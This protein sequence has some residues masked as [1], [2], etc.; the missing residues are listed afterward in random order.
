MNF[1][2]CMDRIRELNPDAVILVQTLYTSWTFDY[3]KKPY[4]QAAKRIND[5]II[6]YC[7]ENSYNIYIVETGEAFD[8]H[9]EYISSDTIHPSAEGNVVLAKLVQ[10]KLFEI[11]LADTADL[12]PTVEGIDRDYLI[13]YFGTPLGQIITFL[14]NLL[15]GNF[16]FAF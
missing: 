1:S 9:N 6:K 4:Q 16:N 12:E 13:E 14:A 7:D 8:G 10:A 2:K 11:G 15:T 5:A 3:A